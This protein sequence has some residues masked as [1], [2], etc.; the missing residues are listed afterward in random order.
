[1]A[2]CGKASRMSSSRS[3]F[4]RE[5][6]KGIDPASIRSMQDVAQI[7]FTT[8]A[9]LAGRF[10]DFLCVAPGDIGRIVT[11]FTS[12]TTGSSKKIAFTPEDQEL[13]VDFFHYGMATLAGP[14][15]RVVIFLPGKTEGSVGDLLKKGLDTS[16][17]RGHC[18]RSGR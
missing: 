18:R 6:L 3:R 12:G 11:L 10:N 15:D 17:L 13:T 4:Y 2:S 14:A 9:M 16:W 8:P 7:P 1:M 5:H